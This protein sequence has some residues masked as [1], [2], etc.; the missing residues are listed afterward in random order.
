MSAADGH[1][2]EQPERGSLALMRLT[3]W[4]ARRLGRRAIAPVVWLVVLYSTSP[5]PARA[6]PSPPTSA[7]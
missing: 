6:A 1:W 4:A 5:A 2:A 3:V 7:G